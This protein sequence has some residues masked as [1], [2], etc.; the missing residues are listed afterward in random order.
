[1]V[2]LHTDTHAVDKAASEQAA[3]E[4]L[5]MIRKGHYIGFGWFAIKRNKHVDIGVVGYATRNTPVAFYGAARLTAGL[6]EQT[7]EG[8]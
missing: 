7:D 3:L 1:M 4:L 8:T 5:A 6:V 2:R